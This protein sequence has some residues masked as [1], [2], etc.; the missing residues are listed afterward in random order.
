MNLPGVDTDVCDA[1][2]TKGADA[3]GSQICPLPDGRR[4][5]PIGTKRICPSR[6][7]MPAYGSKADNICSL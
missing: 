4:K 1:S 6:W 3:R 7:S 2:A 5:S